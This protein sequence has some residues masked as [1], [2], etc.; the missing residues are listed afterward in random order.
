MK[1]AS[2]SEMEFKVSSDIPKQS[3]WKE[4]PSIYSNY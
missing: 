2:A 3:E 1:K 4:S